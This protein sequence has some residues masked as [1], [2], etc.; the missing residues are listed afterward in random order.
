MGGIAGWLWLG[1]AGLV[2]V[3]LSRWF[4]AAAGVLI[5]GG[6]VLMLGALLWARVRVLRGARVA[7]TAPNS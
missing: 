5:P 4:P 3:L 6:T 1:A 7:A 2:A